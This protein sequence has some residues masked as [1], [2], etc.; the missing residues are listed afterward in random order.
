MT[1]HKIFLKLEGN[2][3]IGF[4]KIGSKKLFFWDESTKIKE[5]NPICLLDFYVNE[6]YQRN[7]Y[8]KVNKFFI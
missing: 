1:D 2:K 8:G 7:G 3:A 6:E 4:L 5:L